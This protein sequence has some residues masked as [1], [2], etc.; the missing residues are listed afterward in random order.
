MNEQISSVN[1][2]KHGRHM[3]AR[4]DDTIICLVFGC[5]HKVPVKSAEDKEIETLG[6]IRAKWL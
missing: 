3:L 6:E 1:C 2:P 4:R 5:D